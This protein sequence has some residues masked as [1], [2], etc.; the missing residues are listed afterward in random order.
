MSPVDSITVATAWGALTA[1]GIMV[2]TLLGMFARLTH[3]A[4]ARS[5]SIGSVLLLAAASVKLAAEV[6]KITPY[7]GILVL[8]I[9]AASFSA[10]KA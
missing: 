3:G 10:G 6:L 4:I 2:G 9:G 8:L 7:V 1:S 5:M